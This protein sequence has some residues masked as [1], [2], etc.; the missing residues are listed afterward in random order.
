[1]II[2]LKHTIS[3]TERALLE[4]ELKALQINHYPVKTQRRHYFICTPRQDFDIRRIG[5]QKGVQDVH[6]VNGSHKLVSS[7]W[8]VNRTIID[9]GDGVSIGGN[10]FAM[11]AGPCSIESEDQIEKTVAMLKRNCQ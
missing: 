4:Q 1:M 7:K 6:R 8:K 2:Q 3:E 5:R 10:D 9:F 11:I